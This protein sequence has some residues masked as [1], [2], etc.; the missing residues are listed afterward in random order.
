[1]VQECKDDSRTFKKSQDSKR[2]LKN[3]KRERIPKGLIVNWFFLWLGSKS[4]RLW[5]DRVICRLNSLL[6]KCRSFR[7]LTKALFY[8]CFT[9]CYALWLS[10]LFNFK[11]SRRG[12]VSC[13]VVT[14]NYINHSQDLYKLQSKENTQFL[15]SPCSLLLTRQGKGIWLLKGWTESADICEG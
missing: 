8:L 7:V 14:Y 13:M 6:I 10:L 3:V 11:L 5:L 9:F 12:A 4:R 2:M 1:M 15:I